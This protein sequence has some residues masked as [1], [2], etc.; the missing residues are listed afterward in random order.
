MGLK[1]LRTKMARLE[2][3]WVRAQPP[4]ERCGLCKRLRETGEAGGMHVVLPRDDALAA[5]FCKACCGSWEARP[6]GDE[7]A[8]GVPLVRE[9]R[10]VP[11][12][13]GI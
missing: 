11:S 12:V 9:V 1:A 10:R 4:S 13:D 3:R 8:A 6:V 2:L 5:I 7:N